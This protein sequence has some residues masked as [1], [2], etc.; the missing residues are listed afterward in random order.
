MR[1]NMITLLTVI[2]LAILVSCDKDGEEAQAPE[3]K[4]DAAETT[5]GGPTVMVSADKTHAV[6]PGDEITLTI[7]VSG[8]TL[9]PAKMDQANEDGVGHYRIYLDSASGEDY[10]AQGAENTTKVTIP[11]TI[12]DGSHDLRVVLHN[13]DQT[14]LDPAAEGSVLLIVYRL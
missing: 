2:A 5:P 14:P 6:Q 1:K 7:E 11:E 8:F 4:Q 10:L 9:D 12:T 13:N 3:Q